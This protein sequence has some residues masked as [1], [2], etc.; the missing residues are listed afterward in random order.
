M[1]KR[2]TTEQFISEAIL[3]HGNEYDYSKVSYYNSRTPVIIICPIHGEFEQRPQHHLIDKSKCPK[4]SNI[5]GGNKRRS[6]KQKFIKKAKKKH[7]NKY[8]Y[9]GINY[10]D[11]KTPIEITCHV[12]GKFTQT[13]RQ[14]LQGH[15]C[16]KCSDE[17]NSKQRTNNTEYFT[18]KSID[19]HGNKYNYSNSHYVK[20]K[21]KISILCPIHGEF[22]QLAESHLAGY[23]CPQCGIGGLYN[24]TFFHKFPNQKNEFGFLYLMC[25][26]N[27]N[28]QFLKIGITKNSPDIRK[29]HISGYSVDII[30]TIKLPLFDAYHIEQEILSMFYEYKCIP[31][32]KFGGH[33]ECLSVITKDTINDM[34]NRISEHAQLNI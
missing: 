15:G 33:T 7:G 21:E 31:L 23:G 17:R 2:K 1:G 22:S 30:N 5:S 19:T 28:E 13:P 9:N 14:H 20:T 4:C 12:H 11:S 26:F 24:D 3:I 34:F 32:K 25:I 18:T 8:N 16:K 10:I 29:T 27:D 6:N